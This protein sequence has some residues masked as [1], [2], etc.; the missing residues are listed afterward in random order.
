MIDA[1]SP[2]PRIRGFQGGCSLFINELDAKVFTTSGGAG[3]SGG[4]DFGGG[5]GGNWSLGCRIRSWSSCS[6]WGVA[7]QQQFASVGGRQMDI[8][9][10]YGGECLQGAARGQSW[11]QGMQTALQ[12]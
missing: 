2:S 5:W 7:G 12:R 8:D 6:G 9:Q 11:R 1:V 4:G 10:L 3:D